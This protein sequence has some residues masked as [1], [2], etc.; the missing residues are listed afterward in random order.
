MSEKQGETV[1][2]TQIDENNDNTTPAA[3]PHESQPNN[4]TWS[5]P[6]QESFESIC[7]S[8]PPPIPPI[9]STVQDHQQK[10]KNFKTV[11]IT[12]LLTTCLLVGSFIGYAATYSMF[13]VKNDDLQNQL[14]DLQSQ[15]Y[16]AQSNIGNLNDTVEIFSVLYPKIRESIVDIQC[17]VPVYSMYGYKFDD[18]TRTGSGFVTSVRGQQVIVTNSHVV[19]SGNNITVTFA[20]SS[21]YTATV[22][23]ADAYA[24]LAI[25][26]V[27]KMPKGITSL[28]IVSSSK[29]TVGDTVVAIGSPYGYSGTMT[30][31]IISALGRTGIEEINNQKT[32]CLDITIPDMI[33]HTAEI[34]PGNSGGPLINIH[35]QVIGINTLG[36]SGA[37]GLGFA[38]PSDTIL[39]EIDSL[40]A[41]G[42]YTKHPTLNATGKDMTL[43]IANSMNIDTT[44]GWLVETT[45]ENSN[46]QSGDIIIKAGNTPI[47]N[48][49]N[50]LTYL[51]RNTLPGQ[52]IECTIIRDG[53][54]QTIIIK[55]YALN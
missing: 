46:L 45:P 11:T 4:Q 7:D 24:D 20:D 18:A 47:N 50:L 12:L 35:G 51:E 19:D 33:Q 44:Y 5:S 29:L 14:I 26:K 9:Q 49:D 3:I 17:F 13:N 55:I 27:N 31:G 39:R 10:P 15:L 41:T 43:Q 38:V 34:N 30:T 22:L 40:I 37:D 23:G 52:S 53:Q 1:T 42:K 6:E 32:Y 8:V 48:T 54:Q 2:T 16:I 21:S 36:I 25:L 28:T